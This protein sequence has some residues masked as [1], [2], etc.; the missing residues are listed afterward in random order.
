VSRP[1]SELRGSSLLI[2]LSLQL[3]HELERSEA[4]RRVWMAAQLEGRTVTK[5]AADGIMAAVEAAEDAFEN[6]N[7]L[8]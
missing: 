5:L 1:N 3:P 7:E 6:G 8:N 2:R 4:W